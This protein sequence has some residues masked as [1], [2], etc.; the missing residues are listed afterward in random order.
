[1]LSLFRRSWLPSV[2]V[3]HILGTMTLK[4]AATGVFS[5]ACSSVFMSSNF[6]IPVSSTTASQKDNSIAIVS[7]LLLNKL[8]L[9]CYYTLCCLQL[10]KN[11]SGN[12]NSVR[13]RC[14]HRQKETNSVTVN[15]KKQLTSLLMLIQTKRNPLQRNRVATVSL[16]GPESTKRSAKKTFRTVRT[17]ISHPN[18]DL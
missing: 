15:I 14:I 3:Y 10:T 16:Q 4:T 9:L 13:R 17:Q 18:A 2:S 7:T 8:Y 11:I 12:A 1:M 5:A 6:I